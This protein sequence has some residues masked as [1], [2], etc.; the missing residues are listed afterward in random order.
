MFRIT[1]SSSYGDQVYYVHNSIKGSSTSYY[2]F[3][4]I[5][6]INYNPYSVTLEMLTSTEEVIDIKDITYLNIQ[7]HPNQILY[8]TYDP[9][10]YGK[11][12]YVTI[13]NFA[14]PYFKDVISTLHYSMNIFNSLI[15]TY[16]DKTNYSLWKTARIEQNNP[17]EITSNFDLGQYVHYNLATMRYTLPE[18]VDLDERSF[19]AKGVTS[20]SI[21]TTSIWQIVKH[22]QGT[23]LIFKL[24][25]CTFQQ[26]NEGAYISVDYEEVDSVIVAL[27]DAENINMY[28]FNNTDKIGSSIY[29]D[30]IIYVIHD[31][32]KEIIII[33]D[34]VNRVLHSQFNVHVSKSIFLDSFMSKNIIDSMNIGG[35]LASPENA[36]SFLISNTL[37]HN[38]LNLNINAI[39]TVKREKSKNI[40]AEINANSIFTSKF[41]EIS[42]I[43]EDMGSSLFITSQTTLIRLMQIQVLLEKISIITEDKKYIKVSVSQ[44]QMIDSTTILNI[45]GRILK[46]LEVNNQEFPT[47]EPNKPLIIYG[48]AKHLEKMWSVKNFVR[49]VYVNNEKKYTRNPEGVLDIYYGKTTIFYNDSRDSKEVR[50]W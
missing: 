36:Q 19:E 49:N 41:L 35:S 32:D 1:I 10:T 13:S 47:L 25:K 12:K 15:V 20:G 50:W 24:I 46:N 40:E 48:H 39:S 26:N 22:T 8:I 45:S 4:K 33:Y 2:S 6:N 5:P 37:I 31:I 11:I 44:E 42:V 16:F 23:N 9:S 28:R 29:S 30:K 17:V 43:K 38:I 14:D 21:T 18:T 7:S 3:F 34:K 27:T